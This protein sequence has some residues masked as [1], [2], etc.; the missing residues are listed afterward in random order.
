MMEIRVV[1]DLLNQLPEITKT[2]KNKINEFN[3]K[4]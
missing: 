4:Q 1:E 2:F 3:E